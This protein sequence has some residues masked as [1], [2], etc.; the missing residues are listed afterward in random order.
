MVGGTVKIVQTQSIRKNF[1]LNKSQNALRIGSIPL[2][3]FRYMY[4]CI[5]EN[6]VQVAFYDHKFMTPI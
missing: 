3:L 2:K 6:K 1:Q 5:K 4:A